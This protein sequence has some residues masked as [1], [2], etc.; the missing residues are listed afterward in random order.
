MF[1]WD[2]GSGGCEFLYCP[3]DKHIEPAWRMTAFCTAN[4]EAAHCSDTAVLSL[5]VTFKQPHF[6]LCPHS[7]GLNK[8]ADNNR[9]FQGHTHT[10][11]NIHTRI[12]WHP[13]SPVIGCVCRTMLC[14]VKRLLRWFNLG[15]PLQHY[16]PRNF[17]IN[18]PVL[19]ERC[20]HSVLS[21][22]AWS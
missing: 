14:R 21:L 6:T 7:G 8:Q 20:N 3:P 13:W 9:L 2:A 22:R 15:R 19:H 16:V 4:A 17:Q 1:E 12:P 5:S 18:D 11:T 10:H